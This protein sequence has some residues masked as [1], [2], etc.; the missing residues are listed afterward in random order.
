MWYLGRRLSDDNICSAILHSPLR[1]AHAGVCVGRYCWYHQH[2]NALWSEISSG[3]YMFDRVQREV[4][5][6]LGLTHVALLAFYDKYLLPVVLPAVQPPIPAPAIVAS[7]PV[8]SKTKAKSSRS[9]RRAK[10][11]ARAQAS[12]GA[13]TGAATPPATKTI[14]EDVIQLA[15]LPPNPHR[16]KLV[17]GVFGADPETAAAAAL[18]TPSADGDESKEMDDDHDADHEDDGSDGSDVPS[19]ASEDGAEFSDDIASESKKSGG[20]KDQAIDSTVIASQ[21]QALMAAFMPHAALPAPKP[22]VPAAVTAVSLD[23]ADTAPTGAAIPTASSLSVQAA[24]PG[25]LD[26]QGKPNVARIETLRIAVQA[27]AAASSPL[28]SSQPSSSTASAPVPT[29]VQVVVVNN[30][31][32]A[33]H[34]RRVLPLFPNYVS[35]GVM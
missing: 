8:S 33:A 20:K 26:L 27:A 32:E 5:E 18:L 6:L 16:R 2:S 4:R 28:L 30:A 10:N 19:D 31:E 15:M 35:A 14:P 9:R 13:A 7:P 29:A 17:L 1:E 12:D 21:N 3:C 34:L 11:K 25:V 22:I 24:V 23:R